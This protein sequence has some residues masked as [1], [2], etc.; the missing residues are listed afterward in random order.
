MWTKLDDGILDHPKLAQVG[1]LGF[2]WFVA[3]IV[4][5]NR[6]LTD[7]FIPYSIGH[8]LLGPT[9]AGPDGK[10]WT[11]AVTCGH[12][13]RDLD[14]AADEIV[15]WLLEAEL[16]EL[17]PGGYRVH[18]FEDWNL[19]K[20]EVLALRQVRSEAGRKGGLAKATANAKAHA[21]QT[22]EQ[23]LSNGSSKSVANL[24]PAPAPA[25]APEPAPEIQSQTLAPQAA[26]NGERRGK[27]LNDQQVYLMQ[28]LQ[29]RGE[30]WTDLTPGGIV[31]LNAMYGLG[32]VLEA[33]RRVHEEKGTEPTSGGFPLV[34]EIARQLNGQVPA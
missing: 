29:E 31:K 16:W 4:Y 19:T 12:V 8:R 34:A 6:N 21:K 15:T 9:H 10:L 22:P 32:P 2:A 30:E 11:V 1:T 20:E 33:L 7:G 24:Y 25:P 13:G 27:S 18:D 14:E 26:P 3:S 17:A 5:C 28:K 23:V